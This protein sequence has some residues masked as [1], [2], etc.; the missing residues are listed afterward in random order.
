[1]KAD[2]LSTSAA[3]RIVLQ[4]AQQLHHHGSFTQNF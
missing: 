1:M 2:V 3:A 4:D